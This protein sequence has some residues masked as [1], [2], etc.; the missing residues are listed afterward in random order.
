MVGYCFT[1][2]QTVTVTNVGWYDSGADGLSR[3]FQVGL[4]QKPAGGWQANVSIPELLTGSGLTINGGSATPLLDGHWRVASCSMQ[5]TPGEYQIAGLDSATTTDTIRYLGESASGNTYTNN[6]AY[7]GEFFYAYE[8]I[9]STFGVTRSNFYAAAG[10]EL[11]PMLFIVP[12]PSAV[13]L[14]MIGGSLVLVRR[15]R[16]IL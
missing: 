12:E 2:T 11:G 1:L 16:Q 14:L 8:G 9:P 6:N 15:A 5:L 3:D 13:A 4:W 7:L 10:M